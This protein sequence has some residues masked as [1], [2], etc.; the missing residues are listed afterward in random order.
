MKTE[1]KTENL[2]DIISSQE[3]WER[4]APELIDDLIAALYNCGKVRKLDASECRYR[5]SMSLLFHLCTLVVEEGL[6]KEKFLAM[7]ENGYN[8]S[9]EIENE[10]M[11]VAAGNA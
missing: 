9:V 8:A 7:C 11:G 3:E 2:A 4:A 10:Q 1:I 6:S 5:L